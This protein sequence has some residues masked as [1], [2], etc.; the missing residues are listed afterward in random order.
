MGICLMK[1]IYTYLEGKKPPFCPVS[2]RTL[3]GIFFTD[4]TFIKEFASFNTLK[5]KRNKCWEQEK[6]KSTWKKAF[7]KWPG[8]LFQNSAPYLLFFL[9]GNGATQH[10]PRGC[11]IKA[12]E[13][14]HRIWVQ[15]RWVWGSFLGRVSSHPP[16]T[17]SSCSC[18]YQTANSIL[19]CIYWLKGPTRLR[20][21]FQ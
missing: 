19:L 15:L 9:S 3:E 20:H 2:L 1:T 11:H 18:P 6:K 8:F 4:K 7:W 12:S 13:A 17:P 5:E 10:E 14:H 21:S 16:P